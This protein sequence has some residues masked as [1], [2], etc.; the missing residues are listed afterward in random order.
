MVYA[1]LMAALTAAGAYIAIPIG[2]VPIVL[3]NLFV[4]L[5]GLLLGGRWGLISILVYLTAGAVGLP[6]FAGGTGGIGRFVGPTGGYLIGFAIA[7]YLVGI[8]SE[9]GKGKVLIDILAM[10]AGSFVIYAIG[11]TW[12]KVVTGM[13]FLKSLSVGMLPFLPGDALKIA[14]AIPIAKALRPIIRDKSTGI[15]TKA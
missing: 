2:P 10:V 5:A 6:V 15:R 4:M 9:K 1:A 13:D 11:V 7:A 8:L 14:A 12:L 3:Q